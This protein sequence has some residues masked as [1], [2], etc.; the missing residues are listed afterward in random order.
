MNKR[1]MKKAQ[2]IV[3]NSDR[4]S[5]NREQYPVE[6][7]LKYTSGSGF[8]TNLDKIKCAILYM[9]R[10]YNLNHQDLS[11][12]DKLK[13][14][15]LIKHSD[16]VDTV[17]LTTF[18]WFGTNVGKYDIGKLLDEIRKLKYESKKDDKL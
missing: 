3:I 18:Q 13:V 7:L 15:K 14:E 1:M 10:Q 11:E 4:L 12:K 6:W 5:D 16:I 8:F 17:L 9:D 2:K